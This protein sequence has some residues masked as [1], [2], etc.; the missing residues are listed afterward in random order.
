VNQSTYIIK[1]RALPDHPNDPDSRLAK[2]LKYSLRECGLR[3]IEPPELQ[4]GNGA[5]AP[6]DAGESQPCGIATERLTN[7]PKG[8]DLSRAAAPAASV[9]GK[10]HAG[11]LPVRGNRIPSGSLGGGTE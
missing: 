8:T 5:V 6:P 7:G 3:C 4:D 10:N 11:V 2:S 1:L 9:D